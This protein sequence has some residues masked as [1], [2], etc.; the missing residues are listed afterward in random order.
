MRHVRVFVGCCDCARSI[1]AAVRLRRVVGL[2]LKSWAH[3]N[4][5]L[6]GRT[7]EDQT[8]TS[9]APCVMFV[10]SWVV[11][12]VARGMALASRAP[13]RYSAMLKLVLEFAVSNRKG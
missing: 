4:I 6:G 12:V 10:S 2:W 1:P 7:S 9:R 13:N 8:V 3:F 11:G 5:A